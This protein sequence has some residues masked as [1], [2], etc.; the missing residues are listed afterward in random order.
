M[1]KS[2]YTIEKRRDEEG[3][4]IYDLIKNKEVVLFSSEDKF[5]LHEIV[6]ID[7]IQFNDE[8]ILRNIEKAKQELKNKI[9]EEI[10]SFY[11]KPGHFTDS[12]LMLLIFLSLIGYIFLL[13]N[14]P[15]EN[16][17]GSFIGI[18]LNSFIFLTSLVIYGALI[19][20]RKYD[21][22]MMK[23]LDRLEKKLGLYHTPFDE[24]EQ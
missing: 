1:N 24:K 14:N 7:G 3:N 20:S 18:L 16:F 10:E 9:Q 5:E 19:S 17:G 6:S 13:L 2:T 11:E 8:E 23:R 12:F 15:F 4:I 21:R 22:L